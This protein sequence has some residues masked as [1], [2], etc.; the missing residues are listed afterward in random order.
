MEDRIQRNDHLGKVIRSSLHESG[1]CC[2]EE[3]DATKIVGKRKTINIY[4]KG[5]RLVNSVEIVPEMIPAS[6]HL[7]RMPDVGWNVADQLKW[8]Q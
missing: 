1:G 6:H 4:D 3:A 8:S 7:P 2:V 5:G